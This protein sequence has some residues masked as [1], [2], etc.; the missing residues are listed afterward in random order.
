MLTEIIKVIDGRPEFIR[1][2]IQILDRVEKIGENPVVD[3]FDPRIS[4]VR[5]HSADDVEEFFD[6]LGL[7][8]LGGHSNLL[9][10]R[11]VLILVA[12]R[13]DR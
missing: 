2:H 8:D 5:G 1:P 12:I 3:L 4:F 6:F 10:V 9:V 13:S 7:C 11:R